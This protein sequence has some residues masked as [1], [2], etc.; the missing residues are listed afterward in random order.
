LRV[1]QYIFCGEKELLKIDEGILRKFRE[2]KAI[3]FDYREKYST[4]LFRDYVFLTWELA[5][6]GD[7]IGH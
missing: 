5:I 2:R 4:W 3:L 7:F 1:N 6:K